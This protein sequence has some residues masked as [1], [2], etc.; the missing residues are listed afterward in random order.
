MLRLC[1]PIFADKWYVFYFLFPVLNSA[2][3]S[4]EST[5]NISQIKAITN[6]NFSFR[7]PLLLTPIW[8]T[9]ATWRQSI[10]TTLKTTTTRT[11]STRA[12][13]T[14]SRRIP[15]RASLRRC[16]HD[17]PLLRRQRWGWTL[18]GSTRFQSS[19]CWPATWSFLS[20]LWRWVETIFFFA[21][22]KVSGKSTLEDCW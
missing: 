9:T 13:A 1:L 10:T 16:R 11:T 8:R 4:N 17:A 7:A 5:T 22:C 19:L 15:A 18:S 12:E 20:G 14:T 2:I 21:V 3:Y 6:H